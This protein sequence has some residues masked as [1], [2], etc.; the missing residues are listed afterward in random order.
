MDTSKNNKNLNSK[1]LANRY[2][3]K[4]TLG[5]GAF[6]EVYLA[7]DQKNNGELVALKVENSNCISR[8]KM[9][10]KIYKYLEHHNYEY[11]PKVYKYFETVEGR[12][13]MSMELLSYSL[14]DIF[15]TYSKKFTMETILCIG[16]D[17]LRVIEHLHNL[18]YIHRDIKPNNFMVGRCKNVKKLYIVD[19]GL[20]RK[21]IENNQ[22][23][24]FKDGRSLTGTARYASTNV[25][26]G[27][28]P[29]RRDDLESLGYMLVYFAKGRLPWQGI[30]RDNNGDNKNEH[31]MKIEKMKFSCPL[32]RLC[33]KLHPCFKKFIAYC[34]QLHFE[35]RPDYDYLRNLL[36]NASM[37]MNINPHYQWV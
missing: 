16:I 26:L 13:I 10:Y 8:I 36:I 18:G 5:E 34:R 4:N 31:T 19:F 14:E 11:S 32:E 7:E 25:H 37:D 12:R 6:G 2:L 24:P 22:H 33:F 35:K 1:L 17:S 30:K 27:M 20:S 3:S 29:S 9:E 21:Y 23:I 15:R 28:E